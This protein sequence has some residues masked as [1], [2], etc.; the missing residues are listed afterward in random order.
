MAAPEESPATPASEAR[1]PP[2]AGSVVMVIGR[3]ITPGEIGALCRHLSTLLKHKDSRLVVCDVSALAIP[4]LT[5]VEAVAR[6]QLT[7][8]RA[9]AQIRL[10]HVGARLRELL[11]M[12]GLCDAVSL[13]A[14]L[15]LEEGRKP[16]EREEA[17]GVEKEGDPDD[18]TV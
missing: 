13:G 3:V 11:E 8:R 9:G 6:L 16:E 14:E 4:D 15:P 17:A 10:V 5:A 2:E 1:P 18:L 12:A 7:A